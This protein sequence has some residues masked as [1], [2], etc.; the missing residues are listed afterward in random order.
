[1]ELS[2]PEWRVQPSSSLAE[3]IEND[4]IRYSEDQDSHKCLT[5]HG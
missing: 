3:R 2:N 1:M 4:S 5:R